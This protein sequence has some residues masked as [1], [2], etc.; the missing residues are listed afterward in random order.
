MRS[1]VGYHREL[2][3]LGAELVRVIC[4]E[5]T[6]VVLAMVNAAYSEAPDEEYLRNM[7]VLRQNLYIER[8]TGTLTAAQRRQR[9]SAFGL[10]AQT[11]NKVPF[12][13]AE[14]WFDGAV[15]EVEARAR[16]VLT[17]FFCKETP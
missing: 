3:H 7:D 11:A 12:F 15:V 16:K 17:K 14:G 5:P 4:D 13:C 2:R 1:V 10:A 8:L 6:P 9:S